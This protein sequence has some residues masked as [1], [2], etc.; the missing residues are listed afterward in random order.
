MQRGTVLEGMVAVALLCMAPSG[1]SSEA[2]SGGDAA[3]DGGARVEDGSRAQDGAA[4][5]DGEA[6]RMATGSESATGGDRGGGGESC[7]ARSDDPTACWDGNRDA[8]FLCLTPD[9][10]RQPCMGTGGGGAPTPP[11]GAGRPP[12]SEDSDCRVGRLCDPG[13]ALADRRGCRGPS[14]SADGAPECYEGT[15]CDPDS[16]AADPYPAATLELLGVCLPGNCVTG[17]RI[18]RCDEPD[19]A[20]CE[21]GVC[22]PGAPD[23]DA[24]SGCRGLRCDVGESCPDG[25]ACNADANCMALHCSEPGG[26]TCGQ[27]MRCVADQPGTGCVAIPC[28]EPD[29]TVCVAGERCNANALPGDGGCTPIHCSEPEGLPCEDG[30]VC[31][32]S[33]PVDRGCAECLTNDDCGCGYCVDGTCY[34]QP[35]YCELG[36]A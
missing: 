22:D 16:P 1:C 36:C 3:G 31:N 30:A 24:T 12:C 14:C 34:A 33:R 28:H 32:P 6:G 7:P 26:F 4:D 2:A 35:G 9:A 23:S 21:I 8:C 10:P 19:G 18:L 13:H 27:G 5:A 20:R 11:P 17:C 25:F 29:G 15:V